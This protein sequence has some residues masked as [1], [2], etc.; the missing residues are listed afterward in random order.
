MGTV[1][2]VL[3]WKVDVPA[4]AFA[5]WISAVVLGALELDRRYWRR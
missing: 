4:I 1:Y 2:E 5:A 3:A